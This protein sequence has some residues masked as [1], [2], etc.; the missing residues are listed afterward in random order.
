MERLP[1]FRFT[2]VIAVLMLMSAQ[3]FG[4]WTTVGTV[5][6]LTTTSNNV[7]IGGTSASAKLDVSPGAN[8]IGIFS[9]NSAG[10]GVRASGSAVGV[11]GTTSA[12]T[13]G[14]GVYGAASTGEISSNLAGRF[15][16]NVL[17]NGN[18]TVTGTVTTV[19]DRKFKSN[20]QPISNVMDK[21][22]A[23]KPTTYQFKTAEY[24]AFSLPEGTQ[25]GFIADEMARVF[26]ALVVKNVV[27]TGSYESGRLSDNET[28]TF[29]SVNYTGM[30]P[31]LLAGIQ[32]QQHAI[33]ARD[34]KIATLEARLA[35]LEER[36]DAIASRETVVLDNQANT[37][38]SNRPNPFNGVTVIDFNVP[39]T[40][41]N[42]QLVVVD[43]QGKEVL[44]KTLEQRGQGSIELDMKSL[45]NGLYIYSIESDGIK[46]AGQKMIK[47]R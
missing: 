4:Q 8:S 39:A 17:I 20:I 38:L 44:R 43:A 7:S 35:K 47:Q 45:N 36:L 11:M 6:Q 40:V 19:S 21:L 42:A 12:Y 18:L 30:I 28:N 15:D 1:N 25:Q 9:N 27:N 33:E 31:Y 22:M 13:G 26:P 14:V 23:L 37:A 41:K 24:K 16:G 3:V 46:T 5:V 29:N 32:E 2:Y 10:T 34:E